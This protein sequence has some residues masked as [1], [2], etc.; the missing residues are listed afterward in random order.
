[1]A[2]TSYLPAMQVIPNEKDLLIKI[3]KLKRNRW[4]AD[5]GQFLLDVRAQFF[6]HYIDFQKCFSRHELAKKPQLVELELHD[7]IT[8]APQK[9]YVPIHI[10]YN[11]KDL[12]FFLLSGWTVV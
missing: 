7:P 11:K 3:T 8:K 2:L 9:H 10:K 1:M 6:R 4:P 12:G 5:N